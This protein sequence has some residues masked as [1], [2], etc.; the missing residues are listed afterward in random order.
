MAG[1]FSISIPV[2]DSTPVDFTISER[3]TR[4]V[5]AIS[6]ENVL[7][8]PLQPAGGSRLTFL[9]SKHEGYLPKELASPFQARIEYRKS[10]PIGGVDLVWDEGTIFDLAYPVGVVRV[11]STEN[12]PAPGAVFYRYFISTSPQSHL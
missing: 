12:V 8:V 7:G 2:A 6:Y 9:Y 1:Q 3:V 5:I 4:V 11:T 10:D